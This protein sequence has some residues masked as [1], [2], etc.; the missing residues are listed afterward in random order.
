MCASPYKVNKGCSAYSTNE[1]KPQ[2]IPLSTSLQLGKGWQIEHSKKYKRLYFLIPPIEKRE[3]RV[4]S[5]ILQLFFSITFQRHHV[6][7][8]FPVMRA[9][10]EIQA[11][12]LRWLAATTSKK[13][14]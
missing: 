9:A 14:V 1:I 4:V 5:D 12:V 8:C 7:F 13:H 11:T 10:L 6:H 3:H 2:D